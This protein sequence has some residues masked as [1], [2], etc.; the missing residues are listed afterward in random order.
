MID[1]VEMARRVLAANET[2]YVHDDTT[3]MC[4]A[5]I[6]EREQN[7]TLVRRVRELEEGL[8]GALN[9]VDRMW[10]GDPVYNAL[11]SL[12]TKDTP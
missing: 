8:R 5:L 6:A 10:H 2:A 11:R 4:N 7:L 12:L 9:I 3:A 1:P